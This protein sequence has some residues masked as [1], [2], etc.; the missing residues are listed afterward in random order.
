MNKIK[1]S[2]VLKLD[3][4]KIFKICTSKHYLGDALLMG[5]NK[6]ILAACGI[7]RCK[8]ENKDSKELLMFTYIFI[9]NKNIR[10]D[11]TTWYNTAARNSTKN[12]IMPLKQLIRYPFTRKNCKNSINPGEIIN[13]LDQWENEWVL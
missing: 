13:L 1:I 7:L 12:D 4:D 3:Y 9:T 10:S 2:D 5:E 8:I 11:L 6:L